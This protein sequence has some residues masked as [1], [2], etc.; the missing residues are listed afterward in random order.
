MLVRVFVI[1][2]SLAQVSLAD[3]LFYAV[4]KKKESLTL[5]MRGG[6]GEKHTTK[7]GSLECKVYWSSFNKELKVSQEKK[8]RF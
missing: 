1:S 6:K 5:Q 3:S 7:R 2:G 8:D 4:F